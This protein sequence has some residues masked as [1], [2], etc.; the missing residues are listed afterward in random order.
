LTPEGVCSDATV[1]AQI[2]RLLRHDP[3]HQDH[4]KAVLRT[5]DELRSVVTRT[6]W[7]VYLHVEAAWSARFS[8][9]LVFVVRWAFE[10]G[11]RHAVPRGP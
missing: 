11:Q 2:D 7:D 9:A 10:Q 3:Q 1:I 4:A 6:G 8:D 5:R